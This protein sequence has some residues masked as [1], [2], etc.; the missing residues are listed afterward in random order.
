MQQKFNNEPL[1][2]IN[3]PLE[4]CPLIHSKD[5]WFGSGYLLCCLQQ[6][7]WLLNSSFRFFHTL[8]SSSR[9]GW[10]QQY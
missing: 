9:K 6:P 7:L 3:N 10:S 5:Q 4:S 1:G 8:D 2:D